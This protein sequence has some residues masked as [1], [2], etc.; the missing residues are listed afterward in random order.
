MSQRSDGRNFSNK[1]VKSVYLMRAT[2]QEV[3]IIPTLVYFHPKGLFC[4]IW[5]CSPVLI[6]R[7]GWILTLVFS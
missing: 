5:E 2:L 4:K 7:T 6:L 3:E 1:E